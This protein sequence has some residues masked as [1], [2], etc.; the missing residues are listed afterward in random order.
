[1]KAL[2]FDDV[3]KIVGVHKARN[4][5][6]IELYKKFFMWVMDRQVELDKKASTK[7]MANIASTTIYMLT[8]AVY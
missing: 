6:Y 8:M 1:M 3:Q 2:K 5:T 7:W 4:L